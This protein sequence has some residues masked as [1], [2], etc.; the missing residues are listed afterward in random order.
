MSL[1]ASEA[2]SLSDGRQKQKELIQH[3]LSVG[4][5]YLFDMRV[6]YYML[7]ITSLAQFCVGF[8][9]SL[10]IMMGNLILKVTE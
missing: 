8:S 9:H 6:L 1:W 4:N 2:V 7:P 3:Q 5:V 10:N